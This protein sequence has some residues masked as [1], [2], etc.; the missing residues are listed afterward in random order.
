[1]PQIGSAGET[2]RRWPLAGVLGRL[3]SIRIDIQARFAAGDFFKPYSHVQQET[4]ISS[5]GAYPDA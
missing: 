5:G 2:V 4:F 3:L 1:M